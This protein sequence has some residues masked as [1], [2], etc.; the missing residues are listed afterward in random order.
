M[1][2][3]VWSVREG[4]VFS[5]SIVIFTALADHGI[6]CFSVKFVT[7]QLIMDGELK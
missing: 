7:L 2:I 6:R 3:T 5:V 4:C 1:F